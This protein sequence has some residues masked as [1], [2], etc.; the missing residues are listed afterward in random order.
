MLRACGIAPYMAI[1][2]PSPPPLYTPAAR[3]HAVFTVFSL[4]PY[5]GD[6]RPGV[7]ALRRFHCSTIPR[8]EAVGYILRTYVRW[9]S[10]GTPFKCQGAGDKKKKHTTTGPP[11]RQSLKR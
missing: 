11:V 7:V 9:R 2:T 8:K 6:N 1:Q 5:K 4:K 3:A 10:L